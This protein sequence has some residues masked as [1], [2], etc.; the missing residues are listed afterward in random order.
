[1]LL[2]SVLKQKI[3]KALNKGN[4]K[5]NRNKYS[6]EDL[7]L[8]IDHDTLQTFINQKLKYTP[9]CDFIYSKEV[10]NPETLSEEKKNNLIKELYS[11]NRSIK[12]ENEQFRGRNFVMLMKLRQMGVEV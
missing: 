4:K 11:E 3:K 12:Q 9:K 7:L 1:M 2:L 10:L 5:D 6:F 8:N